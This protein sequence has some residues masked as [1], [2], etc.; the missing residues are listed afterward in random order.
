MLACPFVRG[1]D[2]LS[3]DAP[4]TVAGVY[5]DLFDVGIAVYDAEEEIRNRAVVLVWVDEGTARALESSEFLDGA[6]IVVGDCIHA[7]IAEYG[8]GCALN[9]DQEREFVASGQ[10]DHEGCISVGRWDRMH[11]GGR[12]SSSG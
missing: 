6:R 12:R 1:L 7:E 4:P 8:S 9:L 3:A 5:G 10:T 2:Q 11:R